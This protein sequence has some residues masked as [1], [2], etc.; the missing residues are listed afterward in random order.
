MHPTA[1]DASP[2]LRVASECKAFCWLRTRCSLMVVSWPGYIR[3]WWLQFVVASIFTRCMM[4]FFSSCPIT[5]HRISKCIFRTDD[6]AVVSSV[7]IASGLNEFMP[8][9]EGYIPSTVRS[10]HIHCFHMFHMLS[11]FFPCA[12]MYQRQFRPILFLSNR[13]FLSSIN[14]SENIF[15]GVGEGRFLVIVL[16]VRNGSKEGLFQPWLC[17]HV[18]EH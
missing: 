12:T 4:I 5:L 9:G 3:W 6:L 16:P 11:L 14:H 2:W 1:N 13:V 7:V 18:A 10:F 15:T 8:G 17:D